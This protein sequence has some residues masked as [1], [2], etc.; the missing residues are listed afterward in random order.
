MLN[1][2]RIGDLEMYRF[3]FL[4][5]AQV[6]NTKLESHMAKIVLPSLLSITGSIDPTHAIFFSSEN[7]STKNKQPLNV[8][9][10]SLLGTKGSYSE[11]E[12]INDSTTPDGNI[13][14]VD[15]CFLPNEHEYLH[16]IGGL[17]FVNMIDSVTSNNAEVMAIIKEYYD[18]DNANKAIDEIAHRTV[19][20]LINGSP[21]FRNARAQS[22]AVN[23]EYE[24]QH[25]TIDI[26][27]K[28]NFDTQ[29]DG[30]T[31]TLAERIAGA[32]KGGIDDILVMNYEYVVHVG[33]GQEVYPSEEYTGDSD[34]KLFR[35]KG[36]Q[37]GLHTQKVGNALRTIDTWYEDG[38]THPIPVDPF[39]PDKKHGRLNRAKT[40][41]FAH[42]VDMF[43]AK[44]MKFSEH[45]YLTASL[46]RGGVYSGK[47]GS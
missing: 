21:L 37:A 11:L 42:L 45:C 36:E 33:K 47:K 43:N 35:V 17:K 38:A 14:T 41:V 6:D 26:D 19:I 13:Q 22:I 28:V 12:K 40:N 31:Q 8:E 16:V 2:R 7:G 25:F 32:L 3:N 24:E 27:H 1:P 30:P 20:R 18:S 5:T 44:S 9:E 23:I 39:G 29:L 4:P 46:I 34:K 10:R 15:G